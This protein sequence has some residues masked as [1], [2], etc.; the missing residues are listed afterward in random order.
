MFHFAVRAAPDDIE[1]LKFVYEFSVTFLGNFDF[2]SEVHAGVLLKEFLVS[3]VEVF[4]GHG[5]FVSG[6]NVSEI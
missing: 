3:E 1:Y 6:A 5:A 2:V 4:L